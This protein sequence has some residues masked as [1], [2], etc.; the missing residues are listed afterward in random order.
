MNIDVLTYSELKHQEGIAV[1]AIGMLRQ[2]LEKQQEKLRLIRERVE[3][4][5]KQEKKNEA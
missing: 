5:K 1:E 2:A 3:V 4:V